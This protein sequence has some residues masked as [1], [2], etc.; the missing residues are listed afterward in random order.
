MA[1]CNTYQRFV[2]LR[3]LNLQTVQVLEV[4][5]NFLLVVPIALMVQQGT[6]VCAVGEVLS[7]TTSHVYDLDYLVNV[8]GLKRPANV[9]YVV[10]SKRVEPVLTIQLQVA[11]LMEY[12]CLGVKLYMDSETEYECLPCPSWPYL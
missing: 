5:S 2:Q 7:L 10:W 9:L 3:C 8:K 1:R 6:E 4:L 11:H 12:R